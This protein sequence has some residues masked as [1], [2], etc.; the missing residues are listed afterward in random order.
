[1]KKITFIT[2]AV[3]TLTATLFVACSG[4]KDNNEAQGAPVKV[5]IVYPIYQSQT[6]V[7]GNGQ[8]QYKEILK[9]MTTDDKIIVSEKSFTI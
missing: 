4:N 1:M 2:F 6:G 5:A 7:V 9:N 8:V 3:L